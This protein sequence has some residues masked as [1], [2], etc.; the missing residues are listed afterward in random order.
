M[1]S[2]ASRRRRASSPARRGPTKRTSPPS[3]RSSLEL[4]PVAGHH[5]RHAGPRAGGDRVGEALLGRQPAGGERVA[6][7]GGGR[8]RRER[9]LDRRDHPCAAAERRAEREQAVEREPARDDERVDRV[10]QPP[11]PQRQRRAVDQR[12]RA[13]AAAVQP[14][15]GQR[16]AAV[17]ARAVRA[18]REARPD[19]AHE[20]VVVQVQHDAGA[21]G[22]RGRE[23]AP[24]ERRVDVVGVH[25]PRAGAPHRPG[26]RARPQAAAEQPRARRAA[27][28]ARPES[29]SSTDAGSPSSVRISH[30]RSSTARSSPPGAR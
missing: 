8:A 23:R 14:H 25:D 19:R 2:A 12:L 26:H 21:L 28:P 6:A 13:R 11:L 15:A 20:P 10:R 16:V 4:R 7:G 27:A 18:A 3:A 29:R 17:A 30:A 22:P 24:A 5:Q 9:A 1:A